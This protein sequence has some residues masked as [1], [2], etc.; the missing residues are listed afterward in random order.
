[1]SAAVLYGRALDLDTDHSD[2]PE[3]PFGEAELVEGGHDLCT[4]NGV[5]LPSSEEL[6]RSG[7]AIPSPGAGPFVIHLLR[8]VCGC[9]GAQ[10]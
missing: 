4:L 8:A 1:M 6:C 9:E 10:C 7:A 5:A 2:Q 3:E